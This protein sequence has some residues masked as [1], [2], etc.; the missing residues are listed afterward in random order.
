MLWEMP[1]TLCCGTVEKME[2]RDKKLLAELEGAGGTHTSISFA[3]PGLVGTPDTP[4]P[5]DIRPPH[6]G[7]AGTNV[8]PASTRAHKAR[9]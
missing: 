6:S 7:L 2:A 3:L 5:A 8:P 1:V 4:T 9:N